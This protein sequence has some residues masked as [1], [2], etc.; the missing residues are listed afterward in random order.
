MSADKTRGDDLIGTLRLWAG[1]CALAA[2]DCAETEGEQQRDAQTWLG[3]IGVG[4]LVLL[5]ARRAAV[6]A[7]AAGRGDRAAARRLYMRFPGAGVGG[8]RQPAASARQVD[9]ATEVDEIE[10][11]DDELGELVEVD[12][13]DVGTLVAAI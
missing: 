7:T 5:G 3:S 11:T 4:L 6:D 10:P 8:R 2:K 12:E 1:V 9:E 13:F